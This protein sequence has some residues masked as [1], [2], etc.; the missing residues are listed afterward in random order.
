MTSV[1][2]ENDPDAIRAWITY[3][4]ANSAYAT[5]ILA[6]VLPAYFAAEV[7][8]DGGVVLFGRNWTGQDLWALA[9][10]VG[11]LIMFL[12]T[13][14]LGAIADFS[15]SKKRFLTVFATWGALL[16]SLLFFSTSGDVL[17]SLGLFLLAHLGFVGANVFY[18][19]YL[20]DLTTDDTI[21]M[22]SSRGFA[23]GYLGG[24]LHL[25][26]S[27]ALIQLSDG[28]IPI[29]SALATRIAI[30]SAGIWWLVFGV[31]SFRRLPRVGTSQP[32]SGGT[33]T[34]WSYARFGFGRTLAT[35]RKV[36]R[37]RPLL[38]FIIAFMLFNDGVQTTIALAAVYAT[39][40][41]DLRI[42]VVV[43]GVL[44][45]QLVAFFG[46][47]GFG[48]LAVRI[49]AKRALLAS[50]AVWADGTLRAGGGQG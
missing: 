48:R 39:E 15:A 20:P 45:V 40:T 33:P 2:H 21:D 13:P 8:G 9:V 42:T 35:L 27:L 25:L 12:L 31:I 37:N 26:L 49:G 6:A 46:A 24:G 43:G 41:L 34:W 10:G 7:V 32:L 29:D 38:V 17:L 3:D 16:A 30:G 36:A 11:P 19:A 47:M 18:D 14:V 23:W 5:T 50:I 22:V 44:L 1:G 4:W 28:P